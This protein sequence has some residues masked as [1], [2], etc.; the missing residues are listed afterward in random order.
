MDVGYDYSSIMHYNAKA[1]SKNDKITIR[2]IGNQNQKL[3]QR[4]K[5]SERDVIRLNALYKCEGQ[6]YINPI[7]KISVHDEIFIP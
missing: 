3:G 2:P 6:C 7:F 5:L 1:F 4:D